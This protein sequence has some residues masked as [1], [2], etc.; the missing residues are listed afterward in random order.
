M[1]DEEKA[2][3]DSDY[4]KLLALFIA[5][6]RSLNTYQSEEALYELAEERMAQ[7]FKYVTRGLDIDQDYAMQLLKNLDDNN[8]SS[9]DKA[10]QERLIAAANNL[11]DFSV[12]EE[13]QLAVEVEELL[14]DDDMDFIDDDVEEYA[15]LCK[16]YN[17][18]YSAIENGDIFYAGAVARKLMGM[19][20][21]DYLVYWTMND[22]KVRPWHMELQGYTAHVDEFPSWMIPPIEYNCR[23]YLESV[24]S[25]EVYG[26]IP[27]VQGAAAK[28]K[29]PKELSD[30]YSE[31]LAKCG[32]IFGESHPYFS[33]LERDKELIGRIAVRLKQKY[34]A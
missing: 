18:T 24:D 15:L 17:D 16:K 30:V 21:S 3:H 10:M 1:T 29:K 5:Y 32:R 6:L 9:F 34:Y 26:K 20:S 33:I 12:C 28:I 2:E 8:L 23:C 22:V 13:Y 31:S 4:Q 7:A 11:I 19:S 25:G 14:G 27:Q